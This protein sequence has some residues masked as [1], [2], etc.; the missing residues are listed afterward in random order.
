MNLPRPDIFISA[1]T[2]DLGPTRDLI[3]RAVLDLGAHPVVQAHFAPAGQTVAGL[4][5]EKIAASHAVIHLV[6]PCYGFEDEH[7]PAAREH[8]SY[9]QG[10][11]S[12]TQLEHDLAV[13]LEKPLY[14]FL[15]TE[16]F[17][18]AL[19]DPEPDELPQLQLA[20]QARLLR[21]NHHYTLVKSPAELREH[22]LRLEEVKAIIAREV[23][24][25]TE[26]RRL[27]EKEM[28]QT[29]SFI[30]R[31]VVAVLVAAVLLC[32]GAWAI[33]YRMGAQSR[34]MD[35]QRQ[36]TEDLKDQ[37]QEMKKQGAEQMGLVRAVLG[38]VEGRPASAGPGGGGN[39]IVGAQI[40]V[41]KERGQTLEDLRK[42]LAAAE[43]GAAERVKLAEEIEK[44]ATAEI[45]AA[46]EARRTALRDLGDA[47]LANIKYPDA[48]Q[49]YRAAAALYDRPT[50][51]LPWSDAQASLGRALWLDGKY[52]DS[53]AVWQEV[54][55]E[56]ERHLSADDPQVLHAVRGLALARKSAGDHAEAELLYR[57][58]VEAS[59]RVLGAEH[60]DTL[61]SSNNLA[62]L[63][64]AKGEYGEAEP[65]YR[66]A[67][68]AKE[69]VL[70]AE[71]P[72][73]LAGVAGLAE[74][75]R[76]K[77][78][79][80]EAEPLFRRALAVMERVLGVDHPDTLINVNNLAELLREKGEYDE[81]EPLFRR[82]LA[83]NE[84][85]LGVDHP[86]TLG[87]V[88]I[89][90]LFLDTKDDQAG[91]EPLYRRAVATQERVLGVKHP[92]TCASAFNFAM[93]LKKQDR[94]LEATPLAWQAYRGWREILGKKHN[95]T[96]LARKLLLDL[97]E[98][99]PEETEGRVP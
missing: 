17:P 30:R 45:A 77:G 33:N 61:T 38:K 15:C 13:E 55:A 49:H 86:S 96:Q 54:L 89:L 18:T 46:R 99:V 53:A 68:E 64:Y 32:V 2:R 58:A 7:L 44:R 42:Q 28:R 31:H 73:T 16:D 25:L 80:G 78:E 39:G 27:A 52:R 26:E 95:Y 23:E 98:T 40:E 24:R 20:H 36:V 21:G 87:S 72:S 11:R 1:A 3:E 22:L 56:R 6:G 47:A 51:P 94:M 19:H 70:G 83:A 65:L 29:H 82:A 37:L 85:V 9:E 84:R 66:R 79:Y 57:R 81:A 41:A 67:L 48:V 92:D 8:W 12:Y 97:G 69:R 35:Q 59:E 93:L 5:R 50:E 4:L 91:A 71:H 34:Q 62:G 60:P 74:L 10:R 63:L 75:L 90:A 14:L 88:S 43:L 76:A